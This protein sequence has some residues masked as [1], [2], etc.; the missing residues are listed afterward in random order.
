MFQDWGEK[1]GENGVTTPRR[2]VNQHQAGVNRPIIVMEMLQDT[3]SY[4]QSAILSSRCSMHNFSMRKYDYPG[5]LFNVQI[6]RPFETS[7]E[8]CVSKSPERRVIWKC[9]FRVPLSKSAKKAP[10][11]K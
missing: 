6:D 3:H 8:M 1:K 5:V 2:L 4:L 11:A 9:S 7:Q 10:I